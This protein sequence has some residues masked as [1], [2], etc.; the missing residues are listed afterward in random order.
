MHPAL[1]TR[2]VTFAV[3]M[4][5]GAMCAGTM[6]PLAASAQ[7]ADAPALVPGSYVRVHLPRRSAPVVAGTLVSLDSTR[8]VLYQPPAWARA[9]RAIPMDS[10][11]RIDV[12]T[13]P[14]GKLHGTVAGAVVGFLAITVVVLATDDGSGTDD[15]GLEQAIIAVVLGPPLIATGA[16]LG[17]RRAPHAQWVRVR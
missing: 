6:L 14:S 4:C 5:A 15:P 9:E 10:V 8:V 1:S 11:L 3:A 13:R 2:P 12:R 17:Y 16:W 7:R